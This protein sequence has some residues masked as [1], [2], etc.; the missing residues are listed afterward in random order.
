MTGG[1]LYTFDHCL[2]FGRPVCLVDGAALAMEGALRRVQV[3]VD[4]HDIKRL[5]VAGPRA[6]LWPEAHD[7]TFELMSGLLRD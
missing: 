4:E 3:F 1:T 6:S 7:Y 2:I 5:N